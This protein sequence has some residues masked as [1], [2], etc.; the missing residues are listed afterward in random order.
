MSALG[1]D[2]QRV[3]ATMICTLP[4]AVLL[5]EGQLTGRSVKLPVQIN[6]RP[7]EPENPLLERFY[8]ALLRETSQAIYRVGQ[9]QLIERCL[10]HGDNH[11]RDSLLAY[12]WRFGDERRL[13]TINLADSWSRSC[14]DLSH[15]APPHGCSLQLYDVL[16]ESYSQKLI[17]VQAGGSIFLEIAPT[18]AHIFS[19]CFLV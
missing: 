11:A 14:L 15:W 3:A 19:H 7:E 4:G 5:H 1:D 17:D 2:R 10:A 6:R 16:N 18:S 12:T 8:R 13:I 9:W